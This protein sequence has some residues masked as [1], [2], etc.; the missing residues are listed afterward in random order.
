M[1]VYSF[2]I[3]RDSHVGQEN[4]QNQEAE[5]ETSNDDEAKRGTPELILTPTLQSQFEYKLPVNSL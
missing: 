3:V 1:L 2:T 4:G 5:N